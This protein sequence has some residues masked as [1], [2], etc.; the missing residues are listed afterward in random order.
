VADLNTR[1]RGRALNKEWG[2]GAK[3][4]LYRENGTWYHRLTAF[5]GALIDAH[6]YILFTT[7]QAY[8][9]CPSLQIGKEIGVPGG[10]AQIDG[11]VRVE[12]P[13]DVSTSQTESAEPKDLDQVTSD[14]P[15]VDMSTLTV[16]EGRLKLVEHFRRERNREIIKAKKQQVLRATGCLTCEVCGFDFARVYGHLG[17]GFCEVHHKVPLAEVGTKVTTK[18][19]D[20]AIL[21]ANCHRMVHRTNPFKSIEALKQ[22]VTSD[23]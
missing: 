23:T 6:G 13:D 11:Y 16:R 9:Q 12:S 15:A 2:I 19:E 21:C 20:L 8:L 4:A 1:R 17:R 7:E 3:H 22:V 14:H 10:I 5:P 18:L